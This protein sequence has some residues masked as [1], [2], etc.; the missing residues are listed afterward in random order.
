MPQHYLDLLTWIVGADALGSLSFVLLAKELNS[1]REI[2]GMLLFS[3]LASSG[4]GL[5]AYT[6]TNSAVTAILIG[7]LASLIGPPSYFGVIKN[8]ALSL[9]QDHAYRKK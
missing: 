6:W 4:I 9:L 8:K 1:L 5:L 2:I 3:T 7:L